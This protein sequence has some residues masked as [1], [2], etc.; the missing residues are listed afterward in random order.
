M[1]HITPESIT[2]T[3]ERL[4]SPIPHWK[5]GYLSLKG[6]ICTFHKNG[7]IY[8]NMLIKEV[9]ILESGN[10]YHCRADF[11]NGEEVYIFRPDVLVV[12]R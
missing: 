9:D 2:H 1:T 7:D 3:G 11:G 12:T 10:I 8:E 4:Q 5:K 6:R